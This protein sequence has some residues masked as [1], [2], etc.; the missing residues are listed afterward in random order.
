MREVLQRLLQNIRGQV[1][2][3]ASPSRPPAIHLT[4]LKF[5]Y[6]VFLFCLNGLSLSIDFQIITL[7]HAAFQKQS[8]KVE[9]NLF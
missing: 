4:C 2:S 8:R 9:F 6:E 1:L 3:F 7:H 5:S